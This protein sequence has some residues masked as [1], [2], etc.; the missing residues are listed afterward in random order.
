MERKLVEYLPS[1]IGRYKEMSAIMEAEQTEFEL[2]WEN[3][4]MVLADQFVE[5]ATVN[6]VKRWE[7]IFHITPKATDTL[8][9]RRFRILSKMNEQPPYTLEALK[10]TLNIMLGEKGY[11]LYLD[12]E[13]HELT[14]R[15][16][17]GNET[18]YTTVVE[19]LDKIL[20]A[21]IARSISMFN[22]YQMLST[23]TH[24]ELAQYTYDE[25]RKE[26]LA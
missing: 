22:T 21:N 18:N 2:A 5:T 10:K 25:V 13:K 4:E 1:F 3:A 9:E 16:A 7:K 26:A 19:L 17:L 23:Y 14:V 11:T 6:G 24:G 12:A 20:P 15:L 8:E